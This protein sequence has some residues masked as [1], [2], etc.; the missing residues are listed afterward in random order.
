M[1]QVQIDL[2]DRMIDYAKFKEIELR[3]GTVLEAIAV[4]G[5]DK[6]L[7]LTV[8]IGTEKRQIIAGIAR[9]YKPEEL[10]GKQIIIVV[11]LEPRM[12]KGLES[13]GMLLAVGEDDSK[14]SVL[15]LDRKADNGLLV[16]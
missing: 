16:M 6:L 5:S 9:S 14:V 3:A 8:D 15:T 10:V 12:L 7:R 2:S 11:N 1:L 4:E 13:Q